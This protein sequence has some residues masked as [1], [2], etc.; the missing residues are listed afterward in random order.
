MTRSEKL[1]Y[2]FPSEELIDKTKAAFLS[3]E[4]LYRLPES[5][6]EIYI[7]DNN[8]YAYLVEDAADEIL[9]SEGVS[10]DDAIYRYKIEALSESVR[11]E[12]KHIELI[13]K[14]RFALQHILNEP[15]AESAVD[16]QG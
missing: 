1:D 12:I 7:G 9:E 13:T 10:H 2:S 16:P 8:Y 14:M 3:A 6:G 5:I 4:P 15:K 11:A